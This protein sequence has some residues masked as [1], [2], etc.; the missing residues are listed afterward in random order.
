[1]DGLK[2]TILRSIDSTGVP[3]QST[4]DVN[5]LAELDFMVTQRRI[6][7]IYHG[8]IEIRTP[9]ER[10]QSEPSPWPPADLFMPLS[11]D[12]WTDIVHT[13]FEYLADDILL[14]LDTAEVSH[15]TQ[16]YHSPQDL[17][18]ATP[19]KNEKAESSVDIDMVL[20]SL[21]AC[22]FCRSQH[23]KCDQTFPACRICTKSGRECAYYDAIIQKEV[24]RR[25]VS[26]LIG[27]EKA[28]LETNAWVHWLTQFF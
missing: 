7:S 28:S 24:P 17:A 20:S 5:L 15:T 1:M 3:I 13:S 18:E 2:G 4:Y 12:L 16:V 26:P 23:I 14:F 21:P 8:N 25:F 27:K 9:E 6:H 10:M 19:T 22:G 11:D